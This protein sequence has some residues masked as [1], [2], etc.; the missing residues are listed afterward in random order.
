MSKITNYYQIE[1]KKHFANKE[2]RA[3]VI[4]K[5]GM[6]GQKTRDRH[7]KFYLKNRDKRAKDIWN[8]KLGL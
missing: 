7:V 8:T 4:L 5:C 3:M 6:L 2:E 1:L